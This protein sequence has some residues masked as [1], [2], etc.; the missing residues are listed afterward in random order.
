MPPRL[1]PGQRPA[2][3]LHRLHD[4]QIVRVVHEQNR[5]LHQPRRVRRHHRRQPIPEASRVRLRHPRQR[6]RPTPTIPLIVVSVG[7]LDGWP[8]FAEARCRRH[9][10]LGV[11]VETMLTLMMVWASNASF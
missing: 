9:K 4:P 3:V 6:I 5:L 10:K 11:D 1:V 8:R 2:S 7:V